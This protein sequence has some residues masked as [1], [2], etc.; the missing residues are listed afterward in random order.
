[1][2]APGV[3]V[4]ATTKYHQSGETTVSEEP[5]QK[6][7]PLPSD[8]PAALLETLCVAEEGADAAVASAVNNT[9]LLLPRWVRQAFGLS[10]WSMKVVPYDI[11]SADYA[12]RFEAGNVLGSTAYKDRVIKIQNDMRAAANYPIHEMGHWLD[13]YM[14]HPTLNDSNFAA[15]YELEQQAYKDTFGP[16]CSWGVSEFFAEGFWCYWKSPRA[17]SRACPEFYAYLENL[18]SDAEVKL[19]LLLLGG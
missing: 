9:L 11:A 2:G 4:S 15:I 7:S 17:L 3:L 13:N 18:L 5:T 14:G 10:G 8:S 1:M 6:P 12:D 19:E 16:T